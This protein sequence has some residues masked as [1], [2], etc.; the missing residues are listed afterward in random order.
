MRIDL[1][2]QPGD[3]R[4]PPQVEAAL[5]EAAGDAQGPGAE[6]G[7]GGMAS[8]VLAPEEPMGLAVDRP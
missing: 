2:R 1:H 4:I 3:G 5:A 6:A 8:G 7:V